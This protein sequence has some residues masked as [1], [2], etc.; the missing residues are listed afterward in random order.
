MFTFLSSICDLE[1]IGA[2]S[3]IQVGDSFKDSRDCSGS[4]L[5]STETSGAVQYDSGSSS[6]VSIPIDSSKFPSTGFH[7]GKYSFAGSS[8]LLSTGS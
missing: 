2:V 7:S 6:H 1:L 5:S 4:G 8:G 3:A